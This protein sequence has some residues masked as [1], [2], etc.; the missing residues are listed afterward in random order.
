MSQLDDE[1]LD[2]VSEEP[3]LPPRL[4]TPPPPQ[5]TTMEDSF[6]EIPPDIPRRTTASFEMLD[7]P[8]SVEDE[9]KKNEMEGSGFQG[10]YDV[11]GTTSDGVYEH[12]LPCEL[13]VCWGELY[14]DEESKNV[15]H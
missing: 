6:D 10:M 15:V 12:P 2:S 5:R 4:P 14:G 1:I 3:S 11:L 9:K 8:K 7:E 13:C